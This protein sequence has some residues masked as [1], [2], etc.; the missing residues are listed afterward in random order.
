MARALP[1]SLK[2]QKGQLFF[3][4]SE[5]MEPLFHELV[6]YTGTGNSPNA[7]D[8]FSVSL[9]GIDPSK[10]NVTIVSNLLL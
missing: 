4:D 6:T 2:A 5:E 8:A 9:S 7:M 1:Y 10:Q 3:V